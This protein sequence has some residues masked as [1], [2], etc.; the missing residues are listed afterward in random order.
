MAA[1]AAIGDDALDFHP[2]A[3][4]AVDIGLKIL[5]GNCAASKG[6]WKAQRIVFKS[7]PISSRADPCQ[8]SQTFALSFSANIRFRRKQVRSPVFTLQVLFLGAFFNS[9]FPSCRTRCQ[10]GAH[11][12][13][14]IK[15]LAFVS[16]EHSLQLTYASPAVISGYGVISIR[17]NVARA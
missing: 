8:Q 13:G 3:F 5:L 10:G 4:L 7:L 16:R 2:A 17:Q 14:A 9:F 12:A 15:R 1:L 11:A 6:S